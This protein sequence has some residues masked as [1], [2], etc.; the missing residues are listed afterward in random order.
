MEIWHHHS[1]VK[2]SAK[3]RWNFVCRFRNIFIFHIFISK[4]WTNVSLLWTSIDDCQLPCNMVGD[5]NVSEKRAIKMMNF[6]LR[7]SISFF[8]LAMSLLSIRN[9]DWIWQFDV[10]TVNVDVEIFT[11][12]N[13]SKLGYELSFL[14]HIINNE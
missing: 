10:A 11:I 3:L 13:S 9:V 14:Q 12:E 8:I 2:N 6:Y 4:R 5:A 1:S 7:S